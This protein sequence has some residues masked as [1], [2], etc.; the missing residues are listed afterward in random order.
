MFQ[1]RSGASKVPLCKVFKSIA[2]L[3]D[4]EGS[5]VVN[6]MPLFSAFVQKVHMQGQ[7]DAEE[8][9]TLFFDTIDDPIINR[10]IMHRYRITTACVCGD[11][12]SRVEENYFVKI[13]RNDLVET[14]FGDHILSNTCSV[15]DFK[16]EKCSQMG[17]TYTARL[18]YAPHI[19]VVLLDKYDEKYPVNYPMTL[20]I[21]KKTGGSHSYRLVAKIS[22]AGE[23]AYGH[24]TATC[25]RGGIITFNDEYM[26]PGSLVDDG[27]TVVLFYH[28]LE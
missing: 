16:C 17:C 11:Q 5:G 13:H 21:P 3:V 25:M 19:F 8:G 27:N 28:R 1:V 6:P 12:T 7:Q 2:E 20:D 14:S 22:H 4:G 24:Y 23:A 9:M 26:Y 10:I 18:V 15:G